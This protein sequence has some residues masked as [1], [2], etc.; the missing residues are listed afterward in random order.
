MYT[1]SPLAK[2]LLADWENESKHFIKVMPTDYKKALQ[3]LAEE[4]QIEELIAQ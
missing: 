4:E 3:R 2:R 1:N